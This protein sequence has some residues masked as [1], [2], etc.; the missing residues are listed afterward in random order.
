MALTEAQKEEIA[1]LYHLPLT[2]IQVVGAGYNDRLF[3]PHAKPHPEPVQLVYA[4]KLSY[5]KGVPWFLRALSKLQNLPWRL[6]LVGGGSGGEKQ[7]C[8]RLA[9]K[10]AE[11]VKVHGAV[12]QQ[13]LAAIMKQSHIF[14]L[15]SFYEGLP[16]VVLEALACGCRVIAT[17]LPGL[18]EIIGKLQTPFISLV[19]IPRLHTIDSP[20]EEDEKNFEDNLQRALKL[21]ITAAMSQPQFELSSIADTMASFSWAGVFKRVE[22]VYFEALNNFEKR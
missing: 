9:E 22:R 16:L 5:A 4:G 15:P 20:V 7:T 12:S 21:Q 3:K 2:Q 18:K 8:L 11:R 19:K 6:H 17:N 1:E 14:I 10:L 13:D